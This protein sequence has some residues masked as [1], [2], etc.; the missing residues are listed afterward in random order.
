MRCAR[1]RTPPRQVVKVI[2]TRLITPSLRSIVRK[3]GMDECTMMSQLSRGS[4]FVMLLYVSTWT[5]VGEG[6]FS[7]LLGK[8]RYRIYLLRMPRVRN[9]SHAFDRSL[10]EP[11]LIGLGMDIS[12]ALQ[13]CY[14]HGQIHRDV[15]PGNIFVRKHAGRMQFLLGDFGIARVVSSDTLTSVGTEHF[16]APE[17]CAGQISRNSDIYSL[18]VTMFTLAGGKFGSGDGCGELAPGNQLN[19]QDFKRRGF[20]SEPLL[21]ILRKAMQDRH[22]RYQQPYDMFTDLWALQNRMHQ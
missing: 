1:R 16:L 13:A 14:E 3:H 17:L 12:R 5:D 19:W 9:L 21:R 22:R 20:V 15:K 8:E 10:T 18:G 4:E 7:C 6:L 11:E 2:D